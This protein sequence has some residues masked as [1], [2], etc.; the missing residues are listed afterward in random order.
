[1]KKEFKPVIVYWHDA[2]SYPKSLMEI[3]EITPV[4]LQT[5]G[6]LYIKDK[7]KVALK[8]MNGNYEDEIMVIPIGTV[9]KIVYL[10][11]KNEKK[12]H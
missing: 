9:K 8:R 10:E 5:I 11:E 2:V 3:E 12:K 6:F 4:L 7:E 1:M